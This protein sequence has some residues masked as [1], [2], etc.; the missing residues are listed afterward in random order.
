MPILSIVIVNIFCVS[1][2]K[3]IKRSGV[4]CRVSGLLAVSAEG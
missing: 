1:V 2:H 4:L 3:S